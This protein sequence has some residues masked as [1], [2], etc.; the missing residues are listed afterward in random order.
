[1]DAAF[2]I[3]NNISIGAQ[4]D[5]AASG[6]VRF[7]G[8]ADPGMVGSCHNYGL[9]ALLIAD[10]D[11]VSALGDEPLYIVV[12]NV[13]A[14]FPIRLREGGFLERCEEPRAILSLLELM[15]AT[16]GGS[17][18]ACPAFGLRDLL[19]SGRQHD[20]A[21]RLAAERANLAL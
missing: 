2:R 19:E 15:A 6:I 12:S 11:A 1:M 16:P 7:L 3:K 21:P 17:W 20:D 5:Q 10:L 18:A 9:F 4:S 13:S 14:T 8:Q